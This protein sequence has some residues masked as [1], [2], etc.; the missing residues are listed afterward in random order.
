MFPGSSAPEREIEVVHLC[1]FRV[2]GSLG[3]RLRMHMTETSHLVRSRS[4]WAG[5]VLSTI[6]G[7]WHSSASYIIWLIER[8]IVTV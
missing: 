4:A 3:T 5:L 2:P 1:T 7:A 8:A 6:I